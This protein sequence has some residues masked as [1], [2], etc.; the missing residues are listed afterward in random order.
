MHNACNLRP[1]IQH[2]LRLCASLLSPS[3]SYI[4]N[5]INP[6]CLNR[7]GPQRYRRPEARP[8]R[9]SCPSFWAFVKRE[10]KKKEQKAAGQPTNGRQLIVGHLSIKRKKKK[11]ALNRYHLSP[12]RCMHPIFSF[13][14]FP[15]SF[16]LP[17]SFFPPHLS[18]RVK[19]SQF[20]PR[21]SH[22][23]FQSQSTIYQECLCALVL[24]SLTCAAF[25][26]R[27]YERAPVGIHFS[28]M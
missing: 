9:P 25:S 21:A 18:E 22:Q 15:V 26:I 19:Q 28:G 17:F 2:C 11:M 14:L 13:P 20:A 3:T 27:P 16:P 10:R 6:L 1:T 7:H 12:L 4:R 23:L 5:A 8:N 24:I